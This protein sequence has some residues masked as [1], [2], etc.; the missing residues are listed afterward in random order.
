MRRWS[1]DSWAVQHRSA[2][3]NMT[4]VITVNAWLDSLVR[5]GS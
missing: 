4:L 2:S 1:D 3:V 5:G